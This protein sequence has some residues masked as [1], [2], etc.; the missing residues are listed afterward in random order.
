MKQLLDPKVVWIFFFQ[1]ILLFFLIFLFF[2]VAIFIFLPILTILLIL[3]I[4]GSIFYFWAKLSYRFWKY[5][6]TE[7]AVRIERGVIWKKYIS[8]PYERIQNVDIYRGVLA[9]ILGLSALNIQT[10]GYSGGGGRYGA[11]L[12]PEGNL[13]GIDIHRAEQLRD[14]LI[15]RAKGI[16]QGL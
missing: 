15:K 7:D 4:V 2:A 12:T 13:P 8:I 10:A 3:A 5:E 14:D 9:R 16:R 11:L 6:I 1:Y